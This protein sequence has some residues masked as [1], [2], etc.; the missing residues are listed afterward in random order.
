MVREV[1]PNFVIVKN[2]WA[3]DTAI[4]A[5]ELIKQDCVLAVEYTKDVLYGI[6]STPEDHKD[7]TPRLPKAH[8]DID[9]QEGGWRHIE[10]HDDL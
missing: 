8:R 10:R 5:K 4:V 9:N 7:Y 6:K 1:L 3:Q 2:R